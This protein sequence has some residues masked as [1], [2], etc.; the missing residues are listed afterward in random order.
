MREPRHPGGEGRALGHGNGG[1]RAV[2]AALVEGSQEVADGAARK[3]AVVVSEL[4]IVAHARGDDVVDQET[5]H[6]GIE[7]RVE[8]GRCGRA[9]RGAAQ[10]SGADNEPHR[11]RCKKLSRAN[12]AS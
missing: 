4:I 1:G 5:C 11:C 3:G 2:A 9:Y 12:N 10:Q 6:S 7:E 8:G